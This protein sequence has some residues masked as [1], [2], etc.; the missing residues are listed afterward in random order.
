MKFFI[1]AHMCL[2]HVDVLN[3]NIMGILK[4]NANLHGQLDAPIVLEAHMGGLVPTLHYAQTVEVIMQPT[5]HHACG[6]NMKKMYWR[7]EIL[8]KLA[9]EKP[10]VEWI[11]DMSGLE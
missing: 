8:I 1:F 2:D 5:Q 9:S 11:I 3:A 4:Q 6:T 10:T 7:F